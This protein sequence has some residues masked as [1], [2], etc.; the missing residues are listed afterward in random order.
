MRA[1][2]GYSTISPSKGYL[3][4]EQHPLPG[5]LASTD[6]E[7]LICMIHSERKLILYSLCCQL[8]PF[9]VAADY[10][11]QFISLVPAVNGIF[12]FWWQD[13]CQLQFLLSSIFVFLLSS[14]VFQQAVWDSLQP[15]LLV[16]CHVFHWISVL[17]IGIQVISWYL[18]IAY[19]NITPIN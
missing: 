11:L 1:R 3:S 8:S 17:S 13:S 2:L 6:P 19:L 7:S 16:K 9:K 15:G 14:Q 5:I 4:P 18:L 12:C 10:D